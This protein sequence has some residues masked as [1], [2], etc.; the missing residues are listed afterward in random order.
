MLELGFHKG[1]DRAAK[2]CAGQGWGMLKCRKDLERVPRTPF[3]FH[4]EATRFS[5]FT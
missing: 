5:K 2:N 3:R 4:T 1:Q